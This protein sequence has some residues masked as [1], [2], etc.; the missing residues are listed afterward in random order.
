MPA[1]TPPDPPRRP[2]RPA[3]QAADAGQRDRLIDAAVTLFAR[4]GVAATSTKAI[5]AGAGV[6][7]ALVHYLSLIHIS[8]PTRLHK[9]SRMPSSA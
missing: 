8:E 9:V 3:A 5:A 4:H 2:G 7:P 1:R 6:T